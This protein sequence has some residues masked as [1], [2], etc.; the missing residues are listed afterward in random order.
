MARVS[1]RMLL[2]IFAVA[3]VA[4]FADAIW[5]EIVAAEAAEPAT[6]AA[7]TGLD[8]APGW[9]QDGVVVVLVAILLADYVAAIGLF[10]YRRWART[11]MLWSTILGLLALPLLPT[12]EIGIVSEFASQVATLSWGA[13]LFAAYFGP[14]ASRFAPR[15][16]EAT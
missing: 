2:A 4:M 9:I 10:F 12:E 8:A 16:A 7:W 11:L 13:L 5:A 3:T 1:I 15:P 14:E 6:F